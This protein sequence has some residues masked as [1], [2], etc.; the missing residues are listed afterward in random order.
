MTTKMS[1]P[2]NNYTWVYFITFSCQLQVVN[3]ELIYVKER[4][5]F[6]KE[7]MHLPRNTTTSSRNAR[8]HIHLLK[9]SYGCNTKIILSMLNASTLK[10]TIKPMIKLLYI[11]YFHL[12]DKN[13]IVIHDRAFDFSFQLTSISIFIHLFKMQLTLKFIFL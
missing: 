9:E 13:K 10:T 2:N 11:E 4:K 3:F 7:H 1:F 5:H 12:N 6:H 8:K